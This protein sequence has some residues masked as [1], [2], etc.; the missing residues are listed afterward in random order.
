[1]EPF[2]ALLALCEGN[3]P[4]SGGFPSQRPVTR[5]L[6]IFFDLNLNKQ[7]NK[8]SRCWWFET[9]SCL[10]WRDC[11]VLKRG[12]KM[13]YDHYFHCKYQV[14]TMLLIY[15]LPT[16]SLEFGFKAFAIELKWKISLNFTH[17]PIAHVYYKQIQDSSPKILVYSTS[18]NYLPLWTLYPRGC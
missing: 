18:L 15:G 6:D 5:S 14:I 3:P 13:L 11:N 1:M 17:T 12:F 9:P 7:L 8:Q 16:Q 2:S 10:L 4:V